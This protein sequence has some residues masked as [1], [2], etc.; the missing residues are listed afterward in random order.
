[1]YW[2]AW[3]HG[4][5]STVTISR[6]GF[7]LSASWKRSVPWHRWRHDNPEWCLPDVHADPT[8]MATQLGHPL[9][10]PT[11]CV[12]NDVQLGPPGTF[13]LVTGS[14]MS[15]KS[16]L[17]RSVGLN[18]MLAM[19]GGPVCA[20]H[21][22]L[23]PLTVA[24]SMRNTDSLE[25]GTSF[26]MAELRRLK[27]IVNQAR[28]AGQ[29]DADPEVTRPLLYLLDEILQGTNSAERRIAVVQVL[30]HLLAS[31]AIGAIST[32]DLELAADQVLVDSAETVHFRESFSG[33]GDQRH[34]TF[35]YRMQAGVAPTT[36]ALHLLEMVGLGAGVR[37]EE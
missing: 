5:V 6:S 9:L 8:F 11:T 2:I 27:A 25:T 22:Q 34:M 31:N 37:S 20:T 7:C 21:L 36:N 33:E 28:L 32:H 4:N 18:A 13:L 3:R 24:T 15:G 19:A 16:T 30:Q 23:I 29:V 35:D 14:N 10:P 12:K 1:M 26:F 17:L